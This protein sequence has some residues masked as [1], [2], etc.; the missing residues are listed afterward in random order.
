MD[1]YGY[2]TGFDMFSIMF[3]IVFAL[4]VGTII[5][6]AIKG[7]SE[8][9]NNN[10]QPIL[11]INSK[12]FQKELVFHILTHIQILVVFIMVVLVTLHIM[13]L[14]NLKVKIERSFVLMEKN[15]V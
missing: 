1:L 9:S 3:F 14:L 11:D 10:K 2:E 4:I 5:I 7:I 6:N 13:L 12:L 8:W 15:M